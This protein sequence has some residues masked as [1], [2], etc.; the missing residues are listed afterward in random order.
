AEYPPARVA[1]ITGVPE[2]QLQKAAGILTDSASVA[3]YAW[4]G[5]GQSA[6]ASQTDRAIS[7][8][9][10][11]TGSYGRAGGNVPGG[12][13]RFND[14]SGQDLL[15]DAQRSKALG[16]EARPIGPGRQGW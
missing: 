5:V 16:L 15:T 6:T 13:G 2:E 11:L 7:I 8:L 14:I 1:E 9:Y 3:Y 12:A 4:N 10:G